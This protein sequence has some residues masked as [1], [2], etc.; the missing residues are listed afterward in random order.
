MDRRLTLDVEAHSLIAAGHQHG[1]AADHAGEIRSGADNLRLGR[2]RTMNCGGELLGV[3]RD[4]GGAAID[5]VIVA[6]R[7]DDDWFA[8]ALRLLD[9][10]ADDTLGEHSLGIVGQH[11]GA[12]RGDRRFRMGDDRGLAFLTRRLRRLPIGAQQDVYKRQHLCAVPAIGQNHRRSL[13]H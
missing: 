12:G 10:G 8:E 2:D 6:L 7:I 1:F 13:R 4:Q 9:D 5:A 3:R 11:H